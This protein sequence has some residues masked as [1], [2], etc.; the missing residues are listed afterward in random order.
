MSS[1]SVIIPT[2]NRSELLMRA[3][4][5]VY[6]QTRPADEVIVVDDGSSDGSR[7]AV[8]ASFPQA[9]YL[10][11]ANRGVSAARNVGIKHSTGRWLAFLDSDDEWQPEKLARQ[12]AACQADPDCCV[13]HSDEIWIRKGRRVNPMNKH[14]KQGGHIFEHC[15]PRCAISPSAVMIHR[16]VFDEVGLFDESLPACEDY[17]LWL[18]ICSRMPVLF[19]KEALIT[20]YGGHPDQL[21][22]LHW[23]M[24]R[25]RIRALIK[26]IDGVSLSARYRQAAIT[27]L[28]KKIEIFL[29]GAEKRGNKERLSEYRALQQRY[30]ALANNTDKLSVA[31]S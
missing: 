17:D 10:S 14:A 6:A 2:Y 8:K 21:S 23:G 9:T 24:D 27:M 7:E 1:I 3:L 31:P 4:R 20:K 28:L 16:Q 29:E 25:F 15:L 11:Q 19:I 26:L 5:S 18:R 22:Q 12:Y 30:Q 13:I